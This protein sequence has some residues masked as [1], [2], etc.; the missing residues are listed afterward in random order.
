M[1]AQRDGNTRGR[2][3][4][5]E[6]KRE[7]TRREL[8]DAAAVLFL[9]RGVAQTSVQDVAAAVGVSPR[10][11]WHYFSVKEEA[12]APLMLDALRGVS[13]A[14]EGY[15]A[16]Q[17]LLEAV[18]QAAIRNGKSPDIPVLVKLLRLSRTA[19]GLHRI[20]LQVNNDLEERMVGAIARRAGADPASLSVRLGAAMATAAIRITAEDFAWNG[21]EDQP[22]LDEALRL[23]AQGLVTVPP[24]WAGTADGK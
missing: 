15:P 3:P 18:G 1:A 7:Q 8:A 11:F 9:E 24:S 12:V 14:L 17:P 2:P 16:E 23:L 22:I 21:D 4:L 10:T 13:E 20:W 5:S 19:P 6:R